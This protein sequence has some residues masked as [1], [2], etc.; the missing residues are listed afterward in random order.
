MPC[1]LRGQHRRG[2]RGRRRQHPAGRAPGWRRGGGRKFTRRFDHLEAADMAALELPKSEL[3][4][5]LASL[6]PAQREALEAAAARVRSYHERQ[7]LESWSLRRR[8]AGHGRHPPRARKTPLDRVGLYVPGGR[9]SRPTQFGA[10]ERDP[11][12][13]GRCVAELIMVVPTPRGREEPLV[14]AAAAITGVDRCSPRS[15]APRPWLRWP[16]AQPNGSSRSTRSSAPATPTW[17][18]PSGVFGTVGIDMVAGPSG[19][20]VIPTALGNPDWV[21]MDLFAQA[22]TR[23]LAQSILLCTDARLHRPRRRQHRLPAAREMP[24][25]HHIATSLKNRGALIHDARPRRSLPDH[26]RIAPEHL[27]LSL[28]DLYRADRPD[29][30]RRRDLHR[31]LLGRGWATTAPAP[32]TCCRRCAAHGT[33]SPLGCP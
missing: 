28:D 13:G 2:H 14:L 8:L 31:S 18:P 17:R 23:R 27:E 16:T 5:A 22:G 29:P 1:W 25:R 30:P 9:A 6:S 12:Q 20:A 24:R 21:A 3:Q 4:A 19:S 32:T 33:S 10:D 11:R 7:V 26:N 15:A